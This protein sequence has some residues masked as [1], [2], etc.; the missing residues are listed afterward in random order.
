MNNTYQLSED[1]AEKEQLREISS[2]MN[3]Q[4]KDFR[5]KLRVRNTKRKNKKE[6]ESAVKELVGTGVCKELKIENGKL[7]M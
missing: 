2:Q 7:K 1:E 3:G 4:L 5:T 6:I